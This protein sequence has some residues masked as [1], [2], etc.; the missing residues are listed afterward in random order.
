VETAE[1]GFE[2][3]TWLMTRRPDLV[4]LDLL[5]PRVTGYELLSALQRTR[6]P[7]PRLVISGRVETRGQ[8]L[9]PLVLG[10]TDIL[11]KPVDRIELVRKVEMLLRLE[12]AP[13]DLMDPLEAGDLFARIS[14]TRLLDRSDFVARLDR[15]FGLGEKLGLPSCLVTVT[16]TSSRALDRF[17]ET[18]D[19]A[20]RFEDAILRVSARRGVIL[21]VATEW[22]EAVVVTERLCDA[23][24]QADG[25]PD[26]LTLRTLPARR[27]PADY[28]WHALFRERGVESEI[29]VEA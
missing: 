19:D 26:Q 16:S 17:L 7:I 23:F 28:D 25:R 15:A 20:I 2:A 10:A 14:K 22:E 18:T 21:L 27:V 3:M 11:T 13:A 24:A 1:D 29:E 6:Q 9:A 5:M 8:R 12:S 4:I